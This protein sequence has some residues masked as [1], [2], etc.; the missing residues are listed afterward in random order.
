MA[1]YTIFLSSENIF[2]S[3]PNMVIYLHRPRPLPSPSALDLPPG[4][5]VGTGEF[6]ITSLY[7]YFPHCLCATATP[8]PVS[9]RLLVS[10]GVFWCLDYY[11][12][13]SFFSLARGQGS[14]TPFWS[15][16]PALSHALLSHAGAVQAARPP[17]P[18]LPSWSCTHQLNLV[19][20]GSITY[21]RIY[22]SW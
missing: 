17:L 19:V 14:S 7:L 18:P 2:I 5:P 11:S 8:A 1:E 6:R 22:Q 12:W 15:L 10:N 13:V 4:A 21:T 9:S 20:C 16:I 3:Y